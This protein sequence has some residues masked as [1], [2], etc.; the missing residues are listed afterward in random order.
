VTCASYSN[1]SCDSHQSKMLL[2]V[3]PRD[4][5]TRPKIPLELVER[6]LDTSAQERRADA[7][8]EADAGSGSW[9]NP[10]IR[11]FKEEEAAEPEIAPTRWTWCASSD[12]LE[13]A[14][15][16]PSSHRGDSVTVG[17]MIQFL[18]RRLNMEDSGGSAPC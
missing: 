8:T 18:A 15:T 7:A 16:R 11:D 3:R 12:I 10:G 13:R 1:R 9:S 2:P 4:R 14:R 6:L 17:Q 5:K